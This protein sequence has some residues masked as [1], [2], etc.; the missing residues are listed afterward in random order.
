[1]ARCRAA[2]P[3]ACALALALVAGAPQA[4]AASPAQGP[5]TA[6]PGSC[7][8]KYTSPAVIETVTEHKLVRAAVKNPDGSVKTP[9]VYRTRTRQAII[10]QRHITRFETPCPAQMTPERIASL[11]RALAARGFFAG[12]ITGVIDTNTRR[13][14]RAFQK[15]GGLNSPVLALKTA[16]KLG[17]IAYPR[18]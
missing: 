18:P 2:L 17:L 4:F 7:W 16:R 14:I 1:M 9:A 10:T 3:V 15:R 11:Q 6:P 13:A 8:Q 5:E 12:A